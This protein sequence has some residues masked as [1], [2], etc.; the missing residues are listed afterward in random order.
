MMFLIV[1]VCIFSIAALLT[2]VVRK[3]QQKPAL[4]PA[5]YTFVLGVA[6]AGGISAFVL[7]Q[8][9]Q[10]PDAT[11][12]TLDEQDTALQSYLDGRPMVVN[13]W[14]SWCPPCVR[15]MPFLEAAERNH[16][17]VRFVFVNQREH[18][19][20]VRS[21]LQQHQLA[22][23]TVL[24]DSSGDFSAMVGAQVMPTTLFF[25]A[26][27]VLQKRY[28][29]EVDEEVLAQGLNLIQGP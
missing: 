21:F 16:K 18:L 26:D 13:L 19:E 10:L 22:L 15:E 3:Q 2:Y 28:F 1:L 6:L 11:L 29:G 25:S 23:D 9:S 17:E 20:T 4:Q 27:G 12:V 14:A 24:L 7:Q 8:G 5:L